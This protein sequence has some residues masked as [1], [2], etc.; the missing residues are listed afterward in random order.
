MTIR[1]TIT[2][3]AQAL[4]AKAQSIIDAANADASKLVADA[5]ALEQKLTT[6]PAE[7]ETLAEEALAW[8]KSVL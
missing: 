4:R 5:T 8:L 2:Q 6:I 7:V 1:D 3:D